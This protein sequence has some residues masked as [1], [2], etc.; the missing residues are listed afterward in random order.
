[1]N[2][3]VGSLLL[4]FCRPQLYTCGNGPSSERSLDSP[5]TDVGSCLQDA[6]HKTE[7]VV[8]PIAR[9]SNPRRRRVD[10]GS[11]SSIGANF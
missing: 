2:W 11:V 10:Q 6:A 4:G 3:I 8:I 9:R 1:M 7:W 5:T